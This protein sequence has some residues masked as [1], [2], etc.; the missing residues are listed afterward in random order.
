MPLTDYMQRR[1]RLCACMMLCEKCCH[2]CIYLFALLSINFM[3]VWS[4]NLS[5]YQLRFE[6]LS[7]YLIWCLFLSEAFW[8]TSYLALVISSSR[9]EVVMC[10][11]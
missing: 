3:L 5:S 4:G 6:V 10:A 1:G 11:M 7:I 8:R 2:C 9:F